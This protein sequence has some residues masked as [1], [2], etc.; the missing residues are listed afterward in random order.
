MSPG[1][2]YK[3]S[4]LILDYEALRTRSHL[5]WVPK[6]IQAQEIYL[7]PT[8]QIE[9]PLARA[10][11]QALL[12]ISDPEREIVK[13]IYDRSFT[14]GILPHDI[15][16]DTFPIEDKPPSQRHAYITW[17]RLLKHDFTRGC[18]GCAMGHNRHSDEC[19]ARF[20]AIFSMSGEAV[21]PRPKPIA[22]GEETEIEPFI[23]PDP[24]PEE[25]IPE[26]PPRSDDEGERLPA[27]VT[28][29]LPR[30]EVL[31]REDAIAAI[32]KEFDGIGAM[33]TWDL[34][35]VEEEE[36][37]K[38]RAVE[39]RQT[40]YLA[41]LLVICSEKHVELESQY[42]SLKGGICYRGDQAHTEKGNLALYQTMNTSQHRSRRPILSLYMD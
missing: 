18:S 38:R 23:A 37:V 2:R 21:G 22:D 19:K 28:R 15:G 17:A 31:S 12:N 41:D 20:D 24:I 3:G 4:L 34:E 39:S 9:F 42:R 11:P 36:T 1:L 14:K 27:L 16:I 29:Q 25:D 35:M 30:S 7:P 10:A 32:K 8:G 40:I 13:E 26:Y 6:Q 33:G 5:Y